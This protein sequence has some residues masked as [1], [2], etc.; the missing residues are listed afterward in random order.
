M[1]RFIRWLDRAHSY[2]SN[3]LLGQARLFGAFSFAAK[4]ST[5]FG[6][7]REQEGLRLEAVEPSLPRAELGRHGQLYTN[8]QRRD[9]HP[10]PELTRVRRS[11]LH[12]EEVAC[13]GRGQLLEQAGARPSGLRKP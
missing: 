9:R 4:C 1:H 2:D 10:R 13:P 7:S 3:R 5:C 8:R 12:D 6:P 11:P